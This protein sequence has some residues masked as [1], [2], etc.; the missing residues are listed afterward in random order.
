M[1]SGVTITGADDGVEPA[2]L[3]ALSRDFPFVEWGVLFS[4]T[5]HGEPRYPSSDWLVALHTEK[6]Q[7]RVADRPRLRLSAHFCGKCASETLSGLS[8]WMDAAEDFDRVQING[9]VPGAIG[10]QRIAKKYPHEL[11]LQVRSPDRVAEAEAEAAALPRC[12]LLIDPSGGRGRTLDLSGWPRPRGDQ[13]ILGRDG[14]TFGIAGGFDPDNVASAMRHER[15]H[16]PSARWID[17]ESGVRDD[18]DRFDLG[19]ARRVLEVAAREM[20]LK[21]GAVL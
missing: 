18:E 2:A 5:R 8:R 21:T 19:K 11:I 4:A 13:P 14:V 16:G 3:V 10:L 6:Q 7:D 12:S 15:R 20:A 9:W 1:I 17:M